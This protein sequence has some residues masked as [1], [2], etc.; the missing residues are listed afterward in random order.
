MP[1]EASRQA[2]QAPRLWTAGRRLLGNLIPFAAA[3]PLLAIGAWRVFVDQATYGEGMVWCGLFVP[4][5]WL[6]VNFLGLYKNESMKRAIRRRMEASLHPSEIPE[7]PVFVGFA[8]PA[9]RSAIDPHEDIGFLLLHEDRIEFFGDGDR[10]TLPKSCLQ[11]V[12][13]RPNPH[14]WAFLGGWVSV[15]GVLEGQPVRMLLEP[16][17]KGTLLGNR[18]LRRS[19]NQ[20]IESWLS[21]TASNV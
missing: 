17:E 14:S 3:A 7:D 16:R 4:A 15:E 13:L 10:I 12:R 5:L 6:A 2:P 19:L 20:R 21:A 11:N 9:Y 18:S 8:R 1:N